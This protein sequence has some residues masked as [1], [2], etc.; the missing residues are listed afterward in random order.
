MRDLSI[1]ITTIDIDDYD[2][3]GAVKAIAGF[4]TDRYGYVV[5]P[6]VD[7]VIRHHGDARF[8]Q[9][10]AQ[11]SYVLMDS[12]FLARVLYVVKRQYLRV[13]LGSDLT[14]AL[15]NSVVKPSD[16][17]VLVGGSA[18][19]AQM[20]REKF[21]LQSLHHVNPPMNFIR[22]PLEVEQCLR[23]IEAVGAFRFCFLAIGS[24]QQE[25][26]AQMLKD[27]GIARGL[28]LCIGTAVNYLT[29]AEKRAPVW[30][31]QAGIEWLFRLLH[32]PRRMARRYLIRGPRIFFLLGR[33]E[34]RVRRAAVA[35]GPAAAHS[36][37]ITAN[38]G[39]A[40]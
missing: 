10:Y 4:G 6:N 31:Q 33:I 19:Q 36:G 3:D 40:L 35:A 13:C 29:G 8:R 20:L 2:L 16:V 26:I 39:P 21:G 12:R 1:M 24:P 23:A 14:T 17:T 11:A 37:A 38:S 7:H 15:F 25:I 30:M 27:R 22:D 34:V 9:L 18:E 28:A 5:T 32:N